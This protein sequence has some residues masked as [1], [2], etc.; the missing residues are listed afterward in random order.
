MW[1]VLAGFVLFA[2]TFDRVSVHDDG[3][4]YFDFVRKR[5]RRGRQRAGV[6]VRQRV[7]DGA[8]LPRLAARRDARASSTATTPPRSAP[9][10]RRRAAAILVALPRLAHPAR[11]RPAARAGAAAAD[12][13]RDAALLLRHDRAR[14]TSTPPTRCTRPRRR[15]SCCSRAREPRR[16]YLVAAGACLGLMLATRYANV[17]IPVGVVVMFAW[18]RA[19]R[20]LAWVLARD[21]GDGGAA[22]RGAGRARDPV[23][24]AVG[25][26]RRA[27]AA[28]RRAGS[29]TAPR[30]CGSRRA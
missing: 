6:P 21:G 10:S 25:H 16:R 28:E 26:A 22:L 15:G 23:R 20:P 8:V 12:A 1:L 19:W 3:L 5:L 30:P 17:A 13:V 4:V 24:D 9:P 2:L 29:R 11:A 27:R 18:T 7:L 14:R